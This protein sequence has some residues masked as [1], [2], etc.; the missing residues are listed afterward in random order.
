MKICQIIYTYPPHATGGADIYAE[1]IS[2]ELSDK[3]HEVVVITTQPY[4]GLSSLKPFLKMENGIKVY[5]F[6][7]LNIYSWTNTAEKSLLLKM[8]WNAF[9]IWNLHA[10]LTIKNILKKETP[11][12]VHIHTPTWISLSAFDAIKSLKIPFIFTVH[13]YILL[14]RRVSLLHANGEV[15][16]NPRA[17]CK[18][19]QKVSRNIVSSKPDLV[20]SP[21]KFV[22][23]M[24]DNNGFFPESKCMKLPLGITPYPEKT[25]KNYNTIDII[26]TGALIGHK[27]VDV[28][29]NAFKNLK[30]DNIKLHIVGKG[31]EM[32]NLKALANEDDKIKFYGFLDGDELTSLQEKANITVMP[33]IWFE[34]SPMA[35]YES[36]KYGTPVIGSKIGGI[37]ELIEEGV[38]GFL[39]DPGN[40]SELQN[41]L[42]YLIENPEE[43]KRLE[44]GSF[45]SSQKYDMNLHVKNLE[46]IYKEISDKEI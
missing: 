45:K 42:Q 13:E 2:K 44:K 30:H 7:P 32:E 9:D 15:C 1:R 18:L 3:G 36:F 24:L 27:G 10:Y 11:D 29:I 28:L 31:E 16:D 8:I 37:P 20:L 39:Y 23:E 38:N 6:Y 19:Y 5:R 21:S 4:D 40:I 12:V 17:I 46:K 34:N 33:S 25:E 22:L 14:C 26:Y 41:L 35:I 43:L